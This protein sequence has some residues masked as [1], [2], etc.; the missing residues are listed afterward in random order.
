MSG[1]L[2]E[3]KAIEAEVRM[4]GCELGDKEI[5]PLDTAVDEFG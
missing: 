2:A 3:K 5:T 1:L 4:N